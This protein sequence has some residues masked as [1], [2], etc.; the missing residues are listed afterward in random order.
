MNLTYNQNQLPQVAKKL[1]TKHPPPNIYT[2]TGN[3]GAGKTTLVA[4][5]CQQLGVTDPTSS[6]TFAIVNEYRGAAGPIYHLD[7]YRLRDTEEALAAGLEEIFSDD[8]ATV[9]IEWPAV[10]QPLLPGGV[11]HLRLEHTDDPAKRR[12]TTST[13]DESSSAGHDDDHE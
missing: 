10:I 13:E 6:P 3:L 11:V 7:C 9:F 8:T 5:C 1:L 12:L 2:L 4:E